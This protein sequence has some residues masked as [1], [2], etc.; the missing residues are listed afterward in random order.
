MKLSKKMNL[1]NAKNDFKINLKIS[2]ITHSK[3]N[4]NF[5]Q[6]KNITQICRQS[7]ALENLNI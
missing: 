5:Q 6:Q 3:F 2:Y 1:F 7:K 4:F